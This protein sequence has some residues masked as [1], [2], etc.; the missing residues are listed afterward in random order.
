MLLPPFLL[1]NNVHLGMD[2][3]STLLSHTHPLVII[4][5]PRRHGSGR[6]RIFPYFANKNTGIL[7]KEGNKETWARP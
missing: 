2:L 4:M 3:P 6:D 5:S 1:D 7:S